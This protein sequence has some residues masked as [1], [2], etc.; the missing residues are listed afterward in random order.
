[1][2]IVQYDELEKWAKEHRTE[3]YV[4]WFHDAHVLH[5]THWITDHTCRFV[6]VEYSHRGGKKD[7]T[8]VAWYDDT[9]REFVRMFDEMRT[10][11][12]IQ[13]TGPLGYVID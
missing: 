12:P 3:F 4:E 7:I 13:P 2:A 11:S 1:M 6:M 8:C 10:K 9:L 5:V